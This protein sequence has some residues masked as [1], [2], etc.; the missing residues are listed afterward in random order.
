MTA[1]FIYP[2]SFHGLRV[3]L[4]MSRNLE[5]RAIHVTGCG[6]RYGCEVSRLSHSL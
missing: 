2:W 3:M 1:A 4:L 6:G 5:G